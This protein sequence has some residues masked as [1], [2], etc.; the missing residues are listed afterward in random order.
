M[1]NDRHRLA[2]WDAAIMSYLAN[3]SAFGRVFA[4][5]RWVLRSLRKYLVA[6]HAMD[7][8]PRLFD[9]WR[10]TFQHLHPNTRRG[11]EM[12][13]HAFCRYRRRSEPDCFLPNPLSFARSRPHRQPVIMEP[14]QIAQLL[15]L[16]SEL[17]P[18]AESPLLPFVARLAIVLLYTAG[19]R[20]GEVARLRLQ[21]VD[22]RRGVLRIHET[23]FHKSRWVPMSASARAELERY[24]RRRRKTSCGTCPTSPLLF[25]GK[26]P[27]TCYSGGGLGRIVHQL[28]VKAD[29]RD[30]DGNRARV[31]DVRHS[32]AVAALRR[33]YEKGANVQSSLPRLAIYMG[34]VS[35]HSTAYYLRHMPA[36]ITQA[37]KRFERSYGRTIGGG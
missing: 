28:L 27:P 13:V 3:R 25:N 26:V 29:I 35:I 6:T 15:R 31:H 18:H 4:Q 8:D 12:A 9:G 24:F 14:E 23:K 11:R 37:S 16:A 21:D 19:L 17:R 2:H 7:L 1:R 20:R 10:K 30:T 36:V 5:E 33:W 34:H 22:V 32:F